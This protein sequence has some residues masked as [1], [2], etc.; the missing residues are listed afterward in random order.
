MSTITQ[1]M[2]IHGMTCSSCAV[3]IERT[4]NKLQGIQEANVNF[5]TEQLRV[6]F[7]TE[8]MSSETIIEAIS[9]AGY[10]AEIPQEGTSLMF[11][12]TGMT[13]ASCVRHVEQALTQLDGVIAAN[14]NLASERVRI[15]YHPAQVRVDDLKQ[16]VSQAGYQLIEMLAE[17]QGREEIRREREL[18]LLLAKLSISMIFA[19]PLVFIAMSEM[20]GISLPSFINPDTNP[21]N[22]ALIQLALILPI[23]GAGFH[24]YTKGFGTL[25]RLHP[26]MDSLIA[27]GTSA[28][29]G[30]S[31]WNTLQIFKGHSELVMSLYYE[32]AGVIIALILLGKYMESVSKSRTSGAI[33]E[34]MG[35]QP[36][37]ALI[38]EDGKEREVAIEE[39]RVGDILLV[40][41]G[42]RIPVDGVILE[43]RT[44]V[45]ESMLTGESLPV[46]K[47]RG[48]SVTGASMNQN[49]AIQFSA[50]HVGKDTALAQIIKLVEEAQGSKAPIARMADVIS[51][52][53]VPV[54][55]AIAVLTG[56]AWYFFSTMPATFA[57][58][59]FVSVLV[60]ACPCA[61]GLATPTAI[62]VGTGCGASLGILIKG[63]EPLEVA[64]RIK[65]VVFDK[66][67][68]LT[69]GKPRVTDILAFHAQNAEELLS[70]AASAEQGSEHALGAA[71]LEEAQQRGLSLKKSTDFQAVPGQ[72]I[73]VTIGEHGV[74]LGNLKM[75]Q[76]HQILQE[77]HPE[78]ERL[79]KEG[80]T[81]MYL[82]VDGVFVGII[83]V[84]DVV[85]SDS[86]VAIAK[87]H[88][89]GIRTVMLTGDNQQ[90]AQAIAKQVG[91]DHVVAQVLPG[92]KSAKIKALQNNG[93]KV[94]MVG[95][96][97]NDAPALIQADLGIAIGSGTDVAMESAQIVLMK[98]SLLG[99]VTAIQLS[100]ATLRNIKQ[101]LFW[102]FA[103]NSAGIPIAAGV[104]FLFGGPTLNPMIAAAA[105]AMSSVSVVSNALRL[106][107]F[108]P[109][110]FSVPLHSLSSSLTKELL[111]KKVIS[112]NGMTCKNCARH[113]TEALNK[114]DNITS[115]VVNLDQKNA[116]VESSADINNTVLTAAV[117]NAGYTVTGIR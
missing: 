25:F 5:A 46:E 12:V 78:T 114:L 76:Q 113:V 53:F 37:T 45:D 60:I 109:E 15:D 115:V 87:L 95:D 56:L 69:E 63:G 33:K 11:T 68:T 74:I 55:M 35:L 81:P 96:G 23:L 59:I 4:V 117:T 50:T 107:R 39:V 13:C 48:D 67:G 49:G 14:V 104:L 31:A 1:T 84:A 86:A 10:N 110:S 92:E 77:E 83:A 93:E 88:E 61:L 103:Y 18:K 91:I 20:L 97:I 98:N 41:P 89:M 42:E 38:L 57:L 44:S 52:Y 43:G 36:K 21:L 30:S 22:Y 16:A 75:M 62:M 26:N 82:V 90:T 111:M 102:A 34:L 6:T 51:S 3:N 40:K 85:K 106:R 8:E 64:S 80:K 19:I 101:N 99:V 105:M 66:T 2:N 72:G 100:R 7:N 116:V 17:N 27:V 29:V 47:S 28:A 73:Q 70:L 79:A 32:T 24:F 54:V 94:A 112:I 71:I 65:T 58:M 9:S 108:Q